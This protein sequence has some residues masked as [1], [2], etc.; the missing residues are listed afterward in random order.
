M[1]TAEAGDRRLLV[2]IGSVARSAGS[3]FWFVHD[4]PRLKAGASALST[5]PAFRLAPEPPPTNYV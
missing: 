4:G 2:M 1:K 3:T 5:P